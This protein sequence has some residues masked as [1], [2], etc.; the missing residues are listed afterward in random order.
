MGEF[1]RNKIQLVI[2]QLNHKSDAVYF[3]ESELIK[4]INLIGEP[5][6]REKLLEMYYQKYDKQKRINELKNELKRLEYDQA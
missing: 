4:I 5:F 3:P 6:L 2:D 1:A